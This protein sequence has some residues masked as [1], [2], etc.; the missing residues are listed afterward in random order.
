MSET[1][2]QD[3]FGA[4]ALETNA[5]KNFLVVGIGASAGGIQALREFFER[6]PAESGMAYVVILH[7]SPD[8]DSQLASVLQSA[9]LIPVTQVVDHVRVE[10]NRV[11]VIP[12]NKNLA[13]NDGHLDISNMTSTGVRRAP[14]DIFFRTLAESHGARAVSVVL[15]GTGADGSMGMKRVKENGGLCIVQDP[16]EAEYSDMPRHS[17]ATN[18]VDYV[19]PVAEIP[20]RIIAYREQLKLISLP[21]PPPE[22]SEGEADALRDIFTQLRVRTGHDFS[23]YKL[24]TIMRRIARRIGVH[25]LPDIA[26]YSQ[27]MHERPA[28]ATAL[29]KDLLIS[30]TNFFRDAEAF[31]ALERDIIPK[32]FEGKTADDQVRVW[33]PGC[34]TGEEAYTLAMLLSDYAANLASPPQIQVFATDIDEAAIATARDGYYT[35]NDAA[36]VSPERL[37]RYFT[38]EADEGF[39]VRREIR[40]RVLFAVHNLIKD[41]PF[42]HL[43]LATCRNLLIYLNRAAQRRVMDVLHFALNAG[44]YLMLGSSETVDGAS[45]LY[46]VVDKEHRIY[47]GR[48]V[49]TRL[50]FPVPD[51]SLAMRLGKLPVIPRVRD[52]QPAQ[53]STY[54]QLHQRLLEHYAPP[55]V[56]VDEDYDILHMSESAGGFMQVRGGEPSTNLLMLVCTELRL[57]LRA[58]LYQAAQRKTDVESRAL[59]FAVGGETK[60]VRVRVRPVL[61]E[62]E[63]ARGFFLVMFEEAGEA[64][65]ADGRALTVTNDDEPLARRLEEE[66]IEVR[67]QMNA[68]LEQHELQREELKA[69]NEELQAMNEE[70]RAAAEEL[71][72]SKEELQSINEELTTVNQ[73]LKVKIE[74]LRH[75]NDDLR[76]LMN[77]TQIGTVFLDRALRVK[78]FTPRAR[79]IFN[80]IPQDVGRR[81]SD[82]TSKLDDDRLIEDAESVLEKLQPIEREVRTKDG[83]TFLMQIS[84]YRTGE[85]RINGV[86]AAFMDINERKRAEKARF[87]L[88][89]IVESSEDSMLTIDLDR[90]I[91]SWNKAAERLYGYPASEAVGKPLTMLTLPED[92]AEVL[93][94]VDKIKHSRKVEIFDTVRVN[95]D[96]GGMNLEVVLSPVKN[97]SGQVIGVSTVARD[98]T[99]RRRAEE[100]VREAEEKYRTFVS[101]TSDVVYKMS[102]D[103]RE[104]RSLIG[105]EFVATTENPREDWTNIYIPETDRQTVWEAINRAIQTKSIFELE[106]R[107]LRLDGSIGWTFSRAIPVFDGQGEIVEWLGAAQD[108]T[109][110]KRAEEALHESLL[111]RE[112]ILQSS[113]IG[114]WELDLAT[115][116]AQH[117]FIHDQIFGA[118]RPFKEWS[119]EIFLSYIH[120][121][122]R[123]E[124]KRKFDEAIRE[125]KEWDFQCRIVWKDKS[126]HWIEA[127]GN[128]Y[129]EGNEKSSLMVGIV[130]DITRQKEA[131][132]ALRQSEET[133]SALVENAPFGVYL[134]DAEFRLRTTNEGSRKVFSGIEPLIGRDFAEILRI[135]WPEPFATEAIERFRHTLET[136][137]SFVSPPIVEKRANIEEIE[138][139]DWQ[140]HRIILTD[141]SYG[142][143]CYFYDLSE[144][145]RLEETVRRAAEAL[146]GSEERLRL[147]MES[148]TDYAIFTTDAE[149]RIETWNVGAERIFGFTGEEAIGQPGEIIFTP[150]D[151][152]KGEPEKERREARENGR[153]ADERWHVGKDGVRF[154]VSGILAPLRDGKRLTG[155]A[156]I[157]RDLTE[158]RRAEEALRRAHQELEDRVR[159]RTFELA[160]VNESLR[161][162]ISQRIQVERERVRLLRQIVRAQEDERRRIARDIHDHLGQQMTALR[163]NLEALDQGCNESVD[164]RGK[165]EQTKTIAERLDAD[166]D[167][168]AWEL[169]PAALDDIGLAQALGNFVR[170]W[171]KHSGVETEFH[172]TGMDKERL[173]PETETNLYRITQEALNNTLKY[174]K[175]TRVDVLLER[176]DSQVVLIIEDDGVGFDPTRQAGADGDNGM[177]IIG[178]RE[179]AALVGGSLEIESKPKK[180]T[181]V[182]AHVPVRFVEE[183]A[184]EAK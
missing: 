158:H 88:A 120:P 27:F 4:E 97:S 6:V 139:Y 13:M 114:E 176:R 16:Q 77:S 19:L 84:P 143:V 138:S 46:S 15:S 94:N 66:L 48:A 58:A 107:A 144:Q 10:P 61:G 68:T 56:V 35:L 153:A 173:S 132:A 33:V 65:Q 177:G 37:S 163:L 9:S 136:G 98:V 47:Q 141:G 24:P 69:S 60:H 93:S 183:E 103:W 14:V 87:H 70:M 12:P 92:L 160:K 131:E 34:A 11:Y 147:T 38:S 44:G 112:F 41:P 30:V 168:L 5:D 135:L 75:S 53:R 78:L 150:E 25:E 146:R 26:A 171:S 49:E 180:G 83:H 105:K 108:I 182:F 39:R 175:A 51:G 2:N 104:M 111:R 20:A 90:T 152:A 89:S 156:K 85:D 126:V 140:I 32:L 145:K 59:A 130:T 43:D 178:M 149:G 166:V 137:E 179:R 50:I 23:N 64:A 63:R 151:R 28:E 159:E 17:L 40:E 95:K 29:L 162:E 86:V 157:A 127:K 110:R 106:H 80:V 31:E 124:V 54:A 91:T 74:E 113:K 181:T 172:T 21:E 67:G 55:S 155:Y 42:A 45:D 117:T 72:T 164:L 100:R 148:V 154:Y 22:P 184:G 96:G 118:T 79:D 62:E 123:G 128:F 52:S 57:D 129:H 1:F 115:G 36:D 76:N 121:D 116:K 133:F 167:F 169:R 3:P 99:E 165:L 134:V 81:L 125:Q 82:I 8:H 102:A 174:A 122:D 119:Y 71:E 109:E 73:E 170:Q 7:L 161:D 18:L 101:A 142:V